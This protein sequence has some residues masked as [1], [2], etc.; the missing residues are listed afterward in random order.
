MAMTTYIGTV[1]DA[2]CGKR[3]V[4][5]EGFKCTTNRA[6]ADK[7]T[8]KALALASARFYAN[9]CDRAAVELG[10]DMPKTQYAIETL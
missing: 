2:E 6:R 7:W 10:W 5:D 1:E 9:E 4:C 3:F 8:N